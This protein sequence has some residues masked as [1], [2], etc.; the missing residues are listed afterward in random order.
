[1]VNYTRLQPW[2][3]VL[4]LLHFLSLLPYYLCYPTLQ[5]IHEMCTQYTSYQM[6]S[7]EIHLV[8]GAWQPKVDAI[9]CTSHSPGAYSE[10]LGSGLIK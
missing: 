3:C 4:S 6:K 9:L 10:L 1:M 5:Y 8:P 2:Q 7:L